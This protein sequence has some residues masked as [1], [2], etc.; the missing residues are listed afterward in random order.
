ML[1]QCFHNLK[2][3]LELFHYSCLLN[4][5]LNALNAMEGKG[6]LKIFTGLEGSSMVIIKVED[7]GK[8]ISDEDIASLYVPFYTTREEG[9]G[10]GLS[11]SK[12]IVEQHG[13]SIHIDSKIG[14]G[15]SIRVKLP[16]E[17]PREE[18]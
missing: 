2:V 11:I 7:D 15:T 1:F 16:L 9:T 5:F 10:L 13:G 6:L 3:F 4:L 14:A 12:R 18:G 8:G 17:G